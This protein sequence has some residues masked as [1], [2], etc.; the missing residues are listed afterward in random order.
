MTRTVTRRDDT[1]D[2]LARSL[3]R[4]SPFFLLALYSTNI[5]LSNGSSTGLR[6]NRRER[7]DILFSANGNPLAF[8]SALQETAP[9]PGGGWGWSFSFAQLLKYP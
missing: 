4:N 5:S 2:T 3:A 6:F 8:F 1:P 7:P 9:P